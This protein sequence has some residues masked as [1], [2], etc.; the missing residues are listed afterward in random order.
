[1]GYFS[2]AL[3]ALKVSVSNVF[4]RWRKP[5]RNVVFRLEGALVEWP[6][7]KPGFLMRR[8]GRAGGP[9]LYEL[10][11]QF[12]AVAADARVEALV[13]IVRPFAGSAAAMETLREILLEFKASG[14]RIVAWAHNYDH[15]GY[16]VAGVADEILLQPTGSIQPLGLARPL[17]YLGELLRKLGLAADFL[18]ISP[19]KSAME[20]LRRDEPSAE[21][22]EMHGWLMESTLQAHV[23]AIAAGRK[24]SEA[25]VR[26]LLDR[27]PCTDEEAVARGLVDGLAYEDDLARRLNGA[28]IEWSRAQ[29]R[30]L[31]RARPRARGKVA[32]L[33]VEGV[34]VDGPSRRPKMKPPVNLPFFFQ[35][36]AGDENVVAACRQILR[37]RSVKAVVLA[38][39]SPGGSMSASE[40]MRDA[41]ERVA[42][43]VPVVVSMGGVAGSGGYWIASPARWI[44]A[45]PTTLTGSIG[46]L[47]GKLVTEGLGAKLGVHETVLKLGLHADMYGSHRPF[48]D[49][50]RAMVDAQIRHGYRQFLG[51]VSRDRKLPLEKLE[52]IAG[53]KVWTGAQALANGLVDELGSL[54]VA[55]SKARELAGLTPDAAT[56]WVRGDKPGQQ[57]LP[58]LEQPLVLAQANLALLLGSQPLCLCP[59]L[60]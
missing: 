38:I 43:K 14:K 33:P 10:R 11:A 18:Q 58:H 9:S 6:Q 44:V 1:M 55:L 21:V 20:F 51:R 34:I 27:T 56:A 49:E 52:A 40:A 3:R 47:T 37:D 24:K 45:Q 19:Y 22:R 17:S 39:D 46:V 2:W 30:V 48:T 8:L 29:K 32:V 25:D 50:E 5:P 13:L 31:R 59:V 41:I 36:Q 35:R 57:D 28:A 53:G 12:R 23:A 42:R 15:A 26:A 60:I 7:P 54:E 4:R 16:V